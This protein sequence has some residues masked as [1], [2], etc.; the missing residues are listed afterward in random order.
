MTSHESIERW[1]PVPGFEDAYEV[2]THGRVRS[3]DRQIRVQANLR[4]FKGQLLKP[5]YRFGLYAHVNLNKKGKKITIDVHRLVAR[6]FIPNPEDK[7]QVDHIDGDPRN[8]RLENLR[9]VTE[10]DNQNNPNTR[11]RH[12][13]EKSKLYGRKPS[14]KA[15]EAARKTCRKRI[16][17]KNPVAVCVRRTDTG[18]I[19][20]TMRDASLALGRY[21]G[22]VCEAF[23]KRKGV[24]G[25]IQFEIVQ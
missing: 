3:L 2:S 23:R 15:I 10:K 8:N 9:W 25:R 6:T 16:G 5:S 14:L 21:P 24:V 19:F 4:F 20:E 1:A 22:A 11:L 7:P 17:S 12:V 13:G 18:E